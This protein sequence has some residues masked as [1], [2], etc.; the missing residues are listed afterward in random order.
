MPTSNEQIILDIIARYNCFVYQ[1]PEDENDI[2]FNIRDEFY[3]SGTVLDWT[4][5][6]DYNT[7]DKIKLISELQSEEMI[8]TYSAAE[9]DTNKGYTDTIGDKNI[10]GQFEYH[11]GSE[12][13]KGKKM[14]KSPFVPTPLLWHPQNGAIVPAINSIQPVKGMRL[15]YKGGVIEV[16]TVSWNWQYRTTA[17]ALTTATQSGYPYAGHYDNPKNPTI[18]INFGILPFPDF[19]FF[20]RQSACR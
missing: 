18:D 14:I 1:N 5:K 7:K 17:N 11:F 12:F 10:Y 3:N 20:K 9:D 16:G 6:K 2:V 8:L 19:I 4:N 13:V 15:L